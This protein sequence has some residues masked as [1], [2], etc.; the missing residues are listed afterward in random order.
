VQKQ[1][2]TVGG[3]GVDGHKTK[4]QKKQLFQSKWKWKKVTPF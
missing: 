1:W 3:A 2:E 4:Q